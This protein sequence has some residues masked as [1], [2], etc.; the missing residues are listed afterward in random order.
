MIDELRV[1]GIRAVRV[2]H[3]PGLAIHTHTHDVPKL[4]VVLSGAGT[5]RLGMD[6]V[7]QRPFELIARAPFRAHENQY[8]ASGA[9]SLIVEVDGLAHVD[10]WLDASSARRHGL[11]L[12]EAFASPRAAR[13]RLLH[14]A[15][16]QIVAALR[17]AERPRTPAWLDA[18]RERLFASSHAPPSLAELASV[19]GIHPVHLAHAFRAR[20]QQTPLGFVRAHRVFRAVELIARGVPLVEVASAAGF[21]DQSHMTRAIQRARRAPPGMLRRIM[22]VAH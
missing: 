12:A 5:E 20:W 10:R 7:E 21:A 2:H 14:T 9:D 1:D 15:V 16:D 8:H 6:L 13:Q 3:A 17:D 18:A 19:V 22:R 11:Q 4:V